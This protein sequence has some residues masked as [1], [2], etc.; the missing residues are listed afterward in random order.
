VCEI[1]IFLLFYYTSKRAWGQIDPKEHRCYK[2]CS[3][4]WKN[5]SR[6]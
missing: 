1:L 6:L 4:L 5:I 3:G 2:I